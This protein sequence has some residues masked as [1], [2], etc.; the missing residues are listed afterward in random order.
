V[1]GGQSSFGLL[2]EDGPVRRL[3]ALAALLLTVTGCT[4]GGD[5]SAGPTPSPSSSGSSSPASPSATPSR[6]RP[7]KAPRDRACYKLSYDEAVAPTTEARSVACTGTH[8]S[9]TYAVGGLDTVVDGHLLA[10]DSKH[11][12][13]QVASECPRR[14]PSFLGGTLDDLHLSMLRSVWF[15][16]TVETSDAGADWYRCDVIAVAAD[17]RLAPLSTG[18]AGVLGTSAGRDRFG[19][20]GTAQPGTASFHRVICSGDHSW[21]AIRVVHFSTNDYP[22]PG[23]AQQAGQTICKDAGQSAASNSLDFTWSYEWPTAQQWAAGQDYGLCWV[24]D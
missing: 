18:M 24:P 14:L 11:V 16:P 21:R 12:Q 1:A 15:T 9:M 4:G 23:A 2:G 20:C 6:A 22:G 3:L 17:G 19:M 5:Q 13:A 10:V 7:P 8:T